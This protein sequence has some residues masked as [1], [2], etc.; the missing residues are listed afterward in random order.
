MDDAALTVAPDFG[1]ARVFAPPLSGLSYLK[2]LEAL[3]QTLRPRRYLEVGMLGGDTFR[4]ARCAAIGVDPVIRLPNEAIID[5]P[6][7]LLFELTSDRFFATQDPTTL[8]G[9]PLDLAFLDGLHV[10]EVLLRDFINTERHCLPHSVIALHDCV[11]TDLG[12]ARPNEEPRTPAMSRDPGAWAGDVWKMLPT[13]R[14]YRPELRIHVLDAL[15]TGLVLVTGLDPG[16][17]ALSTRYKE[18]VEEGRSLDLGAIGVSEF[19]ASQSVQPARDYTD[20]FVLAR[21]FTV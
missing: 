8:L 21:N 17:T 20:L 6:A 3:H 11:P 14:K 9:G 13:L 18:I 19:V 1:D 15:P 16:N 5:R 4:L 2:V 10:F 7:T 12:M